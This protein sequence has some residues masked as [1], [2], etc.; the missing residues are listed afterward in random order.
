MRRPLLSVIAAL[1][2]AG[3]S[4]AGETVSLYFDADRN[5]ARAGDVVNW[6]VYA[7]FTGYPDASA[8]FGG[9]IGNAF[10]DRGYADVVAFESLMSGNGTP[11]SINGSSVNGINVFHAAL[12]GTDD[13]SN[14]LPIFR[15]STEVR[16]ALLL[17]MDAEGVVSMFENDNILT[18]P[19]EFTEFDVFSDTVNLPAPATALALGGLAMARTR[20]R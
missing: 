10:V 9:F 12:L 7:S 17:T 6:T 1:V 15:I 14:P 3:P 8:Y 2:V 20:R 19:T 16:I 18:L 5:F 4:G 11:P 13:Q